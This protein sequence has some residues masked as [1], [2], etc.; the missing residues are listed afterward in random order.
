MHP[1][2][3]DPALVINAQ[4]GDPA[5]R[6][7]V[8]RSVASWLPSATALRYPVYSGREDLCQD[9][10]LQV[11]LGLDRLQDPAHFKAWCFG[12]LRNCAS[13]R[14]RN[15]RRHP[16]EPMADLDNLCSSARAGSSQDNP[17]DRAGRAEAWRR[18]QAALGSLPETLRDVYALFIEGHTV[19]EI[20][21][22]LDIPRG[23]VASRLRKA[24]MD[25]RRLLDPNRVQRPGGSLTLLAPGSGR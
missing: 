6:H 12:V 24:Q 10:L 7:V 18:G 14:F 25:V 19:T 8:L 13:S 16:S 23:T 21:E 1:L 11:H 5:A 17:E 22:L 4:T 9:V 3:L 15:E 20:S 2:D